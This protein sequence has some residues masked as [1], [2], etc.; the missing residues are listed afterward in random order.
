MR[1]R[2]LAVTATVCAA[3]F[4]LGWP[5]LADDGS[6]RRQARQYKRIKQGVQSGEITKKEMQRLLR[7]Q[8]RIELA[9]RRSLRDGYL[10]P[11]EKNRLDRMLDRASREIYRA[12]HNRFRRRPW[13]PIYRFK[14]PRK[15][16]P[17]ISCRSHDAPSFY[18][19]VF[20]CDPSWGFRWFVSD[21]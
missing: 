8:K 6:A 2:S 20:S 4:L 17:P 16:V 15:L 3:V 21:P 1:R 11:R 19:R 12:K 7:E 5:A 10:S 9:R 18:L 13:P 14:Y